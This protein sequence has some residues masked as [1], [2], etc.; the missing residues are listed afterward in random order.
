M[1]Q[2]RAGRGPV[3]GQAGAF[4]S[5]SL[6][7]HMGGGTTASLA[8]PKGGHMTLPGQLGPIRHNPPAPGPIGGWDQEAGPGGVWGHAG[9]W[10]GG[11]PERQ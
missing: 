8:P 9:R 11:L 10:R 6:L 3:A 5:P 7:S 1:T 4:S 2:E